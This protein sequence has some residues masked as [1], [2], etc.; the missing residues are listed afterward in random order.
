MLTAIS[1]LIRMISGFIITKVI[2]VLAGPNGLALIGQLQ[3][4]INLIMLSAG[5]FLQTAVTK[6]TAE[7]KDENLK[8]YKVWSVSLKVIFVINIILSPLIFLF[9]ND[10]SLLILKTSEMSYLFKIFSFSMPL[11]VLNTLFLSIINGLKDIKKYVSINILLSVVSL[12]LTTL[13]CYFW[14][15][16]GALISYVTNQSLVFFITFYLVRNEKWMKLKNFKVKVDNEDYKKV[17]KFI[18][19]TISAI[20]ASNLSLIVIRNN[21]INNLS[22]NDAGYWQ[23]VWSL[24]QVLFS[25]VTMTLVTYLLPTLSSIKDKNKLNKEVLNVISFTFPLIVIL[26]LLFY[27]FRD[28]IIYLLYSS[29]FKLMRDL[30]LWQFF[31]I[32]IKLIGWVYG[33]V[34]VARGM[35]KYTASTEII[36][37]ISFILIS[38]SLIHLYG[39]VGVTYAFFI[40]SVLHA[41]TMYIIYKFKVY[42]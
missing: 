9:S 14:G 21:I 18:I 15:I 25:F 29:D 31:G 3:N 42:I 10:I 36:F 11:F 20:L 37:A 34:L 8:K 33:Y 2:S 13:L 38:I 28:I 32:A 27:F 40:N 35:V 39:L 4:I 23:G 12:L 16:K 22:I 26:C 41:L 5:N 24:S 6:Y 17:L 1:T 19:I 30:F 7:Y